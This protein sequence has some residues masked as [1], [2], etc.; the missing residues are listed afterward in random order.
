MQTCGIGV[1]FVTSPE[2]S[3]LARSE[4]L[5]A[6]LIFNSLGISPKGNEWFDGSK[7]ERGK[8]IKERVAFK[9]CQQRQK[10]I[11]LQQNMTEININNFNFHGKR[12][13]DSC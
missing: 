5:I 4:Y 8:D 6:Y 7:Q 3:D 1:N 12:I 2:V 9:S 11:H 10:R 13:A